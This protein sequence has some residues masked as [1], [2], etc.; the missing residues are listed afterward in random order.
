MLYWLL[1][2][3]ITPQG[4]LLLSFRLCTD[5]ALF[6][7]SMP[8]FRLTVLV[9]KCCQPD[10][11]CI[12]LPCVQEA[13]CSVTCYM[14]HATQGIQVCWGRQLQVLLRLSSCSS[15]MQLHYGRHAATALYAPCC[16]CSLH[17]AACSCAPPIL[18]VTFSGNHSHCRT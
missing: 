3:L 4:H 10:K 15:A 18:F 8:S 7:T 2:S 17:H 13:G 1:A 11:P 14:H 12:G 6:Q 5:K 16:S 9:L